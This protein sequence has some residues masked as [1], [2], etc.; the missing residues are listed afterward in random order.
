MAAVNV[1]DRIEGTGLVRVVIHFNIPAGNNTVGVSWKAAALGAG[2]TGKTIL[3]TGNGPGQITSAD[4]ALVASGDMV[5]IVTTFQ[6]EDGSGTVISSAKITALAA[7]AQ[8]EW[9]NRASAALKY[10]G[11]SQ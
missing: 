6:A 10:W 3:A 1:L 2:W 8:T 5:E 4:A 11:Y 7:A 9:Q